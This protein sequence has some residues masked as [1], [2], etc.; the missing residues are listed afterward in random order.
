MH[1]LRFGNDFSRKNVTENFYEFINENIS[2]FTES[3]KEGSAKIKYK[4]WDIQNT[5]S[6]YINLQH[7]ILVDLLQELYI[8]VYY[9]ML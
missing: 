2:M 8:L 6:V 3:Q 5:K 1:K 4:T 7:Q 9:K